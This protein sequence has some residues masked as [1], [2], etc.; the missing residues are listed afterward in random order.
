M[1]SGTPPTI[2]DVA[3]AAGVAT[4]TVSRALTRPERVSESTRERVVAVAARMGYQPNPRAR[5]LLS[6]RTETVALLLPDVTNP[7][8]FGVIRGMQRQTTAAGYA[9]LLVDTQESAEVEAREL[10]RLP[11]S[12][13]GLVLAASRLSDGDLAAAA[14]SVPVVTLN[15]DVAGVP[16]VVV[17]SAAGMVD[18]VE[19][20]AS[21]GHRRVA[22]AAGP[23]TS[24]SNHRRWRAVAGA[25]R[26]LGV[27][28]RRLGPFPPTVAAGA[29]AAS[30]VLNSG[31]S[32]VIAFNDVLAIGVLQGL[33]RRDVA[34]PG[35]VSV[36]GCD[37]IFG[38]DFCQPSLTTLT[39][40]VERAGRVATDMLLDLLGQRAGAG[41]GGSARAGPSVARRR[42]LLPT[43]LTVRESTGPASAGH[44]HHPSTVRST[45]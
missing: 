32:A 5:S 7:F 33:R 21:L 43:H 9:Q 2:S 19:H 14:R 13:D 17:D 20:L 45:P 16:G 40:P 25:G 3:R 22:Y 35:A 34:V 23:P 27:E 44:A 6:G 29:A 39:A 42:E 26:R 30:A 28:V 18:A 38:A 37:D 1:P 36:V 8:F 24:W 41:R 31:A 11:K 10:A 4:S 15:R 12:V